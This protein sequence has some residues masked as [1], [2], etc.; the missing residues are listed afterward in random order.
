NEIPNIIKNSSENT[1]KE[2]VYNIISNDL[3]KEWTLANVAKHLC[4]SPSSLKRKLQK[5]DATF[6]E[7][8]LS[9]RMNAA[10]K[11]LRQK[12]DSIQRISQMCGYDSCSYFI[13]VFKKKFN[14]TPKKYMQLFND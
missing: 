2:K 4:L 8:C 12:K 7:I 10:A 14:I 1:L 3:N 9:A 13:T 6:S 5:E 11:L